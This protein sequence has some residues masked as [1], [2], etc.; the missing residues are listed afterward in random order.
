MSKPTII[1]EPGVPTIVIEAEFDAAPELLLKAHTDPEL[2]AQWLGP[3]N[4]RTR[5]EEYD[6]AHGG[7]WR[8]IHVDPEGGEYAFRGVHHGTPSVEGGLART[9]EYE[10]L[11]GHVSFETLTFQRRDDR[12]L[13]RAVSV[14]TS[15]EDRDGM[16]ASG[17]ERGVTDSYERLAELL[18]SQAA[19]A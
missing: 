15:Q 16:L 2:V 5:V 11:P 10:G 18:A 12:T 9:F 4:L 13:L 3:R 6:T 7:R 19:A 14:F 8:L 1:A 17:M